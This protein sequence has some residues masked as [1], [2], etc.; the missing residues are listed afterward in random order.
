MLTRTGR[1][2]PALAPWREID[3]FESRIGRLLGEPFGE[4]EPF[5]W[6]PAVNVVE[7]EGEMTLTAELPGVGPDDVDIE[8]E[9]NVLRIHGEKK[10]EREEK[11]EG[12]VRI[13]ERAYGEFT[14]SFTLPATVAADKIAAEFENGVLTVHMPKTA[15][16]RGRRIKVEAKKK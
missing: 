5:G 10:V 12:K 8:L 9:N 14:R 15:E 7:T 13:Y 1:R 3:G 4:T 16:A 11:E 2:L 6:T